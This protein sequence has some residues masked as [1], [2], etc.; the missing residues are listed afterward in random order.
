MDAA[1]PEPVAIPAPSPDSD[2]SAAFEAFFRETE[3]KLRRALV[4][5]Y[6]PD[7]GCDAASEALAYA[8]EHWERLR[9]MANLPGYLFRVGQTRGTRSRRQPLLHDR[10]TWPEY[11]FEPGL[12]AAL[13]LLSE[14]QRLAVVLV[15]GYGYT[16]HEV[17]ELTGLHKGS[18]QTHAARGLA[19]LRAALVP[20]RSASGQ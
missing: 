4:A 16:L 19:R 8:W 13:A 1:A 5:A 3:S 2:P 10:S 14:R 11:Q 18:V 17:A 6:G 12:P 15:H 7:L 20:P 9:E